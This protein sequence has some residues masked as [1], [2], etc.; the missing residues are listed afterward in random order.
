[1][2]S[3]TTPAATERVPGRV[4]TI[5]LEGHADRT[6]TVTCS[7]TACKMPPRS[8]DLKA[9]RTFA[10]QHAVAH[11][12]V[13]TIRP[14]AACHCR[15]RQCTAHGDTKV[16][17]SGGVVLI[18][19]HDPAVGRVWTVEEVCQVCAPM[20]PHAKPMGTAARARTAEVAKPA[21]ATASV[22]AQA[23]TSV[24]GGFSAP[25]FSAPAFSSAASAGE[26][27]PGRGPRPARRRPQG[28]RSG[29]SRRRGGQG[30]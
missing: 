26:V 8:R 18:L 9:L 3:A 12:R 21:A 6:A 11:A 25:A 4:W 27:A 24:P 1:M 19:R 10:A 22:P 20:I 16:L 17:C 28:Q 5:R 13:A 30:R 15:A 14:D 2:T 23:R 29:T 7:S